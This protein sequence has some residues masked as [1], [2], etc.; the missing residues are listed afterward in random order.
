MF[1][2]S[3]LKM[4][5]C[6]LLHHPSKTWSYWNFFKIISQTKIYK[7][8][9]YSLIRRKPKMLPSDTLFFYSPLAFCLSLA[10]CCRK[11]ARPYSW[12]AFA[13]WICARL[14]LS[15]SISKCSRMMSASSRFRTSASASRCF[16]SIICCLS[17][18]L[19]SISR[20]SL[21]RLSSMSRSWNKINLSDK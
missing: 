5:L 16:S 10:L 1:S 21:S 13:A 12:R 8:F 19:S 3:F 6:S 18:S 20:F 11:S 14:S 15:F 2:L 17:I 9:I 7:I 4:R